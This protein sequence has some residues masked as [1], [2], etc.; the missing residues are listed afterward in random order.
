MK[1]VKAIEDHVL[2]ESEMIGKY[3]RGRGWSYENYDSAYG[4]NG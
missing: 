3:Q 2:D 4:R 1:A